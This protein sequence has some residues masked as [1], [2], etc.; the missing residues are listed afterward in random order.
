MNHDKIESKRAPEP[1]GPYPHARKVGEFIFVSGMGPRKSGQKAIPGVTLDAAGQI[2]SYEFETQARSTIENI[3]MVLEDAGSSLDEVVDVT[4][5]LT[6]M[7]A[8]F[9][10][11]NKVY[12]EYFAKI[13]PTRTTVEVTA[14][15]TPIAVELKV[16]AHKKR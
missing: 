7:K 6:N 10:V 15:P 11:F 12:G 3:K 1:V 8:D 2:E 16:I 9:A 14:L 4:A 13:G 5:F